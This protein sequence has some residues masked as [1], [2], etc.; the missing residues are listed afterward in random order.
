[1]PSLITVSQELCNWVGVY[2]MGHVTQCL[3]LDDEDSQ[4]MGLE[5]VPENG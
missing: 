2:V 3:A 5:G 4:H 1:M